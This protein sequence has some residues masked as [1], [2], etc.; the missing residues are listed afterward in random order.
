MATKP[1]KS[2]SELLDRIEA[3][4]AM[5]DEALADEC[6]AIQNE[7]YFERRNEPGY[8]TLKARFH[9]RRSES[10]ESGEIDLAGTNLWRRFCALSNRASEAKKAADIRASVGRRGG[11]AKQMK[12]PHARAQSEAKKKAL[13]LWEERHEGMHPNLRTVE[14][15][16]VEV[17]RR[18]PVLTSIAVVKRWSTEWTKQVKAGKKPSC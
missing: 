3:W 15:W 16:A 9:A 5:P 7:V 1:A 18:W 17:I 12:N 2:V 10:M 6:D 14:Q 8:T 4:E 11:I 13:G